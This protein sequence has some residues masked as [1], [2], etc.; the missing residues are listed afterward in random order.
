[1]AEQEEITIVL[2][3]DHEVLRE[4]L[5]EKL[6]RESGLRVVGEARDADGA[7][8]VISE[9][10][11]SVLILDVT[12]K[13]ESGIDVAREV[14]G[15]SSSTRILAYSMHTEKAIVLEMLKAG[16]Q[17]YVSKVASKTDL[18]NAIRAIAEGNTYLC[19]ETSRIVVDSLSTEEEAD[20][21]PL[22]AR[23]REVLR[24]LAEGRRSFEIAETLFISVSTVE[25]HRRN[26]M[27]KLDLHNSV[28]LTRYAIRAGITSV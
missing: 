11:P 23:E 16:A 19:A 18:L 25:V 8:E 26:I 13:H 20:S 15:L 17:G 27:R 12:L 22:S 14:T 24:L 5:R 6:N 7:R 4:A 9:L 2:V 10:K 1:M 3:D 28:E 21:P